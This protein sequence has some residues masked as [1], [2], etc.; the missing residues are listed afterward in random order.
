MVL[1]SSVQYKDG[2]PQYGFY[3]HTTM[4]KGAIIPAK[5]P[6]GMFE[7]DFIPNDLALVV[8]AMEAYYG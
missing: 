1:F 2:K 7:E 6:D 8:K 5:S 4:E 3:T